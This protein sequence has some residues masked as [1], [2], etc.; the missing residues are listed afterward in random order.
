MVTIFIG[1]S[2]AAKSQARAIIRRFTRPG[3]GFVPWW[4]AF[5]AGR[6]LLKDLDRIRGRVDAA[7]LLFS[8]EST[9][10]IR[11]RRHAVPNLNVLFEL[12][13]FYGHF[14]ER[15]V[16]MVRYGD[17]YLP[18]D[19]GGYIHIAGSRSFRRGAAVPVGKRTEREF[20]RWIAAL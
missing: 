15:K 4:D 8:P 16:A 11:N 9:T 12:G 13:Y 7:L 18:T 1:S 6:T 5:T 10:R 19:L 20:E 3:L 14:G 17:F 2:S